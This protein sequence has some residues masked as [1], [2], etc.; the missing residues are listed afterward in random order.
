MQWF[1]RIMFGLMGACLLL[2]LAARGKDLLT[3]KQ[4]RPAVVRQKKKM[5]FPLSNGFRRNDRM[6]YQLTF[7]LPETRED[8]T[9]TDSPDL[10]AACDEGAGGRLTYQGSRLICW[11]GSVH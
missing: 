8:L 4:S 2:W 7:F 1:F 6:E 10:Y 3:R 11:E 5:L 9:F